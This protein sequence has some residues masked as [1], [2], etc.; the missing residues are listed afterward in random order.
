MRIGA[1]NYGKY[2][3]FDVSPNKR[4]PLDNKGTKSTAEN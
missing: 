2:L 3:V 4:M 1:G